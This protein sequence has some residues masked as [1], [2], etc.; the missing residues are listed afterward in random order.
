MKSHA[1]VVIVGG[2]AMG[3]GLLYGLAR[4]GWTDVV[5][6]EKGELCSGSTWHAA[7]QCP[8]FIADYNLAKVHDYSNRL[9]ATLESQTGDATGWHGVGGIRFATNDLELDYFKRVQGVA[10]NIGFRME[11][12]SPE[13]IRRVNPFVTTEGVIAGARTFDDGYVDPWSAT[14]A[15]ANAAKA[16]GS[17][18]VK[19]NRVL[20]IAQ[21]PGGEFRVVTDQG[22]ITVEHV[23]NA[24]GCYAGRV[25]E[26]L[27]VRETPFVNM[28]HQYVVTGTVPEFEDREGQIPVMRDPW[29]SAYYRQ[30]QK[31]GLVGIYETSGTREGWGGDGAP[32]WEST[33]E[34]FEVEY[35]PI[36]A[37]LERV[38]QRMPIFAR[39]GIRRVIHGAISHTP[40]SNPLVGP[41]PGVRNY[42]L[43]TGAGI[44]IA[45]G[46]GCGHY[47][48]QWMV[49][50]AAEIN[51]LGMDPRR[52][53]PYAD[54]EYTRAKG[55]RE[56]QDM[57]RLVAPG[58]ERPEGRPRKTTPLYRKLLAKGCVFTTAFG[59]ER[60]KWFSLDGRVEEDTFRR[61]NVFEVVAAECRAVRERVGVMELASFAKFDVTGRDAE[62]FL[63]RI[64]AN[65]M[66]RREGGIVLTHALDDNGRYLTEMTIT[67]LAPDRFYVVTGALAHQRDSDLLHF[68][69][70]DSEDVAITDITMDRSVL[71]VAGPRSR[72]LLSKLTSADLSSEV[73]PW[74]TGKDTEVA[75]VPVRM[76]R[77]NYVGE[78]GWELHVPMESVVA[79]YDAVWAAGEEFGIAD[80]GM[81][82]MNSLRIEKA[83]AGWGAE[84]TNEITPVEANMMRFVKLD[85]DFR[86]REAVERVLAGGAATHMVYL[87]VEAKDSDT[88]G[89]EA[90]FAP[91][92]PNEPT[93]GGRRAI[94]VTTSG[95]YGHATGMSLA[96]AYVDSGYEAVGTRLEVELLGERCAAVVLGEAAWDA[97][98][99]RARG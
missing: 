94:G 50:G 60:P 23:V 99:A 87:E 36:T 26:W 62:A 16:L 97:A 21:L 46:P 7:G 4:E 56:Y 40:D 61:N 92:A 63:D 1:R 48:A 30:E 64:G 85:H 77:V 20:D 37:Q 67:R 12:I 91:G 13:E 71:I 96:F 17:T 52:F 90:V 80:F 54:V 75:G 24:A 11:I 47:L 55:H 86:G 89:G 70:R 68:S 15:V 42:W 22:D 65:R 69:L 45:Q 19:D 81:Y 14:N 74:L 83:Y 49:H 98:N 66:P 84:L 59:W 38:M 82:A 76:L 33:N 2:G 27:G 43:C 57:Y 5:L 93:A 28:R 51:M 34:L 29:A 72:D 73:F 6:V 9:Y 3:V 88:F 8:S 95:G 32:A 58:E 25:N 31:S 35:E 41:A 39:P 53:G 79:L 78:L 18:I 10:A 44:G